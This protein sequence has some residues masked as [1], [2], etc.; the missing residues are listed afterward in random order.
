[1]PALSW[2]Y[3]DEMLSHIEFQLRLLRWEERFKGA[4]RKYD[5]IKKEEMPKEPHTPDYIQEI[6]D[7]KRQ[8]LLDEAA[9]NDTSRMTVDDAQEALMTSSWLP[10][11]MREAAQKRFAERQ[12][13][14]EVEET[15]SAADIIKNA[16][17]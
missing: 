3:K 11:S 4:D 1:M 15:Q 6:V 13:V 12:E 5:S 2:S 16:T 9:A 8:E 10:A 7:K 17:I 14:V